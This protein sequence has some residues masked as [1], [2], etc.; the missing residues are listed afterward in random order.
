MTVKKQ[1]KTRHQFCSESPV[2]CRVRIF[3]WTALSQT[4]LYQD[5][6]PKVKLNFSNVSGLFCLGAHPC[7]RLYHPAPPPTHYTCSFS[8]SHSILRLF[9]LRDK[10]KCISC[11]PS[12]HLNNFPLFFFS[13]EYCRGTW[14][15]MTVDRR[16]C[17]PAT[18]SLNKQELI[19]FTNLINS[20][21]FNT[22][23]RTA[24]DVAL[25]YLYVLICVSLFSYICIYAH[26]SRRTGIWKQRRYLSP[27]W[28]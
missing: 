16:C 8:P 3:F 14:E 18:G 24:T 17:C 28:H 26:F 7:H 9:K 1:N 27:M 20:K 6:V 12:K 21:N 5:H 13:K 2:S 10:F 11:V 4:P 25:S 22:I 23:L 19:W 15:W